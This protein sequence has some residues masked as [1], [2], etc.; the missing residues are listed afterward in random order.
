[1][2]AKIWLTPRPSTIEVSQKTT[3]M[4]RQS[5]EPWRSSSSSSRSSVFGGLAVMSAK[6][7]RLRCVHHWPVVTIVLPDDALVVL[8]GAS[9]SGKSTFAARHF[10]STEV[11]SSDALRAMVADDPADQSATRAAF[12]LLALIARRR[13]QRGRLTVVDATSVRRRDRSSLVGLA[14]S[15]GRPVVAIVLD[16]PLATCLE[17]NA[18]RP[19][20]QVEPSVV[21]RQRAELE[22]SLAAP[23]GLEG[24]GFSAVHRLDDGLVVAGASIRRAGS[25]G[26][27]PGGPASTEL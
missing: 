25:P 18:A 3:K 6:A 11:V 10:G 13:L 2:K 4:I 12:E 5:V 7:T 23:G 1:M 21:E 16:P 15:A 26:Q 17:R 20:R 9:G 27:I 14:R 22:R 24:E 19:D 8:V